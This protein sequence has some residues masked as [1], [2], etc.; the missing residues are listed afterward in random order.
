MLETGEEQ[1]FVAGLEQERLLQRRFS[2]KAT[3]I[4]R[5][6]RAHLRRKKFEEE[7]KLSGPKDNTPAFFSA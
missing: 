4:Q 2:Q 3:I 1:D 6:W 5:A 7:R